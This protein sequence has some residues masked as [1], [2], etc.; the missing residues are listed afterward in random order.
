MKVIYVSI[1][2]M[3]LILSEDKCPRGCSYTRG[4]ALSFCIHESKLQFMG[5]SVA[6]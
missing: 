4:D 3:K 2:D 5:S 6:L 1:L